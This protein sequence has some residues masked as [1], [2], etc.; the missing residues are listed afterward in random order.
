M[1]TVNL[2]LLLLLSVIWGG[3]FLGE[4]VGWHTLFGTIA[5]LTGTALVIGVSFSTLIPTG[6]RH[7][8]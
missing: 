5:V 6:S 7:A 8:G 1:N 4:Q 2:I 3:L